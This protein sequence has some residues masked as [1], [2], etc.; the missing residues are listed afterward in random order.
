MFLDV[1]C[2]KRVFVDSLECQNSCCRMAHGMRKE[3]DNTS[4][5]QMWNLILG[6]RPSCRL[7]ADFIAWHPTKDDVVEELLREQG[8]PGSST[9]PRGDRP[10]LNMFWKINV[11]RKKKI[12]AWKML[13]EGLPTRQLKKS[14]HLA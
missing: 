4:Y 12:C 8:G 2:Q 9:R 5:V 14:R 6:I 10:I 7:E 3:L 13:K 11:P 1:H